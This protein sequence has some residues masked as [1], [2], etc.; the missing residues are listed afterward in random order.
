MAHNWRMATLCR[1]ARRVDPG[2]DYYVPFADAEWWENVKARAV[3][4]NRVRSTGDAT[5]NAVYRVRFEN[6][7]RYYLVAERPDA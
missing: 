3:A 7:D 2:V 4:V 1:E 5:Y 6:G